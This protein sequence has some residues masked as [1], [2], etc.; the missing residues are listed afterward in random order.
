M[1]LFFAGSSSASSPGRTIAFPDPHARGATTF[2]RTSPTF[3]WSSE[4]SIIT[5]VTLAHR[6][7]YQFL[8]SIGNDIYVYV[9]GDRIGQATISGL[10]MSQD[11]ET[12]G[13]R[14]HGFERVLRWYRDN[15][16]AQQKTPVVLTIGSTPI[17]GFIVGVDGDIVD[18]S[19]RLMQYSLTMV[20]LPENK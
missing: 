15:R 13:R 16:L 1:P 12:P 3:G 19:T 11:C 8:H 9:F 5:R 20:I 17:E 2:I 7:N 18:P 4:Q 10:S 14:D 6:G